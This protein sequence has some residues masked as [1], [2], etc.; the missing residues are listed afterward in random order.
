MMS[1]VNEP[2]LYR[3]ITHGKLEKAQ[4]FEKWVFENVLPI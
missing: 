4:D 2:D 1:Y 3:L